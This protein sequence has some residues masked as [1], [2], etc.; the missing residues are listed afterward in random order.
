MDRQKRLAG[1]NVHL[2]S[3]WTAKDAAALMKLALANTDAVVGSSL[4]IN[5]EN[6]SF[7]R[8]VFV[9]TTWLEVEVIVSCSSW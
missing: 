9:K 8:V 4:L 5:G 3:E 6:A 7:N 2:P 1:E